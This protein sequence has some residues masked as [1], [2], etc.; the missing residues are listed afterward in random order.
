VDTCVGGIEQR[1]VPLFCSH[2]Q[3]DMRGGKVQHRRLDDDDDDD[4]TNEWT[5]SVIIWTFAGSTVY[6]K[7]NFVYKNSMIYSFLKALK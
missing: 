4:E 6:L 5:A 3:V 2:S 7:N 1:T